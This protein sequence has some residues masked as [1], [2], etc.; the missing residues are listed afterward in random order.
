MPTP[1]G[2]YVITDCENISSAE[3]LKKTEC[4]LDIGI[5]LLQY[6]NKTPDIKQKRELALKLQ[7]LCQNYKTPFIVN[8]D[9]LLAKEVAAD[10]IHL[11][12]NDVDINLARDSIGDK[13]IGISCYNDFK[14]AVFAEQAGANYIAFGSFFPSSTK[15][16]AVKAD[17][18]LITKSRETLSIPIVAIGGITPE[19]GGILIDAKVDYLAVISGLYS[20]EN[21]VNATLAYKNLFI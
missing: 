14:R 17:I 7:L 10:G 21:T 12:R 6:R 4:I 11:G 1:G 2:L 13:I 3:L 8:D 19:N 18:D 5:A 16:D 15:P 20:A 9:L